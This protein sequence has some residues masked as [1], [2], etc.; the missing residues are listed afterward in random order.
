VARCPIR[1]L[2]ARL[3]TWIDDDR[4]V[5]EMRIDGGHV[6][7]RIGERI[8]GGRG[9]CQSVAVEDRHPN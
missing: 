3:S 6:E 9:L 4:L 7:K 8:G 1:G 5:T 2:N